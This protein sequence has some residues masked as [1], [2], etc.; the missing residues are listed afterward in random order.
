[1]EIELYKRLKR[2]KYK[3]KREVYFCIKAQIKRCEYNE[4]SKGMEKYERENN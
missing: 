1:M 4:A 3:I 2:I